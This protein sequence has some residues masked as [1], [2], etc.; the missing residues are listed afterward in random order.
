MPFTQYA[1]SAVQSP[2]AIHRA[3]S[4]CHSVFPASAASVSRVAFTRPRSHGPAPSGAARNARSCSRHSGGVVA[5]KQIRSSITSRPVCNVPATAPRSIGS[6]AASSHAIICSTRPWSASGA[7]ADSGSSIGRSGAAG[8][9][10]GSRYSATITCAFAPPAPNDEIPATRGLSSGDGQA[11]SAVCTVN[12][13]AVK[14]MFGLGRSACRLGANSRCVSLQHRLGQAGDARRRL[15]MADVRFRRTDGAGPVRRPVVREG[16]ASG[17]RSRRDRPAGYRCRAPRCSR[18]RPRTTP[19]RSS[20]SRTS[21]A[22]ARGL[23]TV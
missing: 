12:G 18:H 2:C 21:A 5:T 19:A 6:S 9:A 22:C 13:V 8:A 1:A 3:T 23:G 10:F 16:L 15:E 14:S 20:A 11:A 4:C 17:R 7:C